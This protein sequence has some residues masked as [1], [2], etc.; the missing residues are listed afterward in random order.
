ML[1]F[2][3]LP[4]SALCNSFSFAMCTPPAGHVLHLVVQFASPNCNL[5]V[6]C[7]GCTYI[8]VLR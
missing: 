5:P 1:L 3:L 2:L 8:F 4:V 7:R 6:I